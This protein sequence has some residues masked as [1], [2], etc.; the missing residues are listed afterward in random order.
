MEELLSEADTNKKGL[1]S[2][3][4][5][6]TTAHYVEAYNTVYKLTDIGLDKWWIRFPISICSHIDNYPFTDTIAVFKSDID[7]NVQIVRVVSNPNEISKKVKY[8]IKDKELYI[9]FLASPTQPNNAFIASPYFYKKV[10]TPQEIIDGS[11]KEV[12]SIIEK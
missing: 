1:L 5:Y 9:S 7:L 4:L 2:K 11:F 3:E 10:G 8:Y 12:K 6:R